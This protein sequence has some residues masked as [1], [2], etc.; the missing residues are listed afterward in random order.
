MN[1]KRIL[2][3]AVAAVM[4][5]AML[6]AAALAGGIVDAYAENAKLALL[7]TVWAELEA[8]ENEL[9]PVASQ[10]T[11][12]VI[13]VYNAAL[14]NSRID[15]GSLS[16]LSSNGFFF[17]VDGM[18][19]A[20]DYRARNSE[21]LSAVDERLLSSVKAAAE[22]VVGVKEGVGSSNVLL[23]GPN[24][25]E[26]LSEAG[27]YDSS[28]TDQYMNEINSIGAVTG[29]SVTIL[30]GHNATGPAIAAAY[31]S[32]GVV[33]YDSHGGALNGTSY[34]CLTTN[35]GITTTDYN[36]GWAYNAGSA[37]YIDGRYIQ[38]HITG[39]L[40]NTIVWMAICQGMKASGNGTTGTAL[41][42]A[43]AGC[44][45]GYSQ[46]VT[47]AGDYVYE[48]TFWNEMKAG[49]T[50]K[51]ALTVMKYVHGIPDPYGTAYPIVMS[52]VDP[53]P[54]NPDAA[55]NVNCELRIVPDVEL[56]SWNMQE[57]VIAY[58]G[59]STTVEFER[60]PE[61]ANNYSLVWSTA[62]GS[63]AQVFGT[64]NKV[65]ISGVS[66]GSTT[67]SAA[68]IKNGQQV[69]TVSCEVSVIEPPALNE[70]VN[71][72]GGTLNFTSTTSNYPWA[73]GV[74]DGVPVAASGNAGVDN[75]TSTMQLVL[76]MEAGEQLTFRWKASSEDD[77]DFLK[78]Y[79]NNTQFGDSLSGETEWA[80]VTYTAAASGTYT[81]QWRFIKDQYVGSYDDCGY[82]DDVRYI[83]NITPG[84]GDVNLD[85]FVTSED[86]LLALRYAMGMQDL[87]A[88]Q[89]AQ[90]D[91]NGDGQVT[92][93]DAL[94]ILRRGM[95]IS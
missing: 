85:G 5:F 29:G 27:Y 47:F 49:A 65:I 32:C 86:A 24:Y 13:A 34:L 2:C 75:S 78:F 19:C 72:E 60:I 36:N 39:T 17:T 94:I 88:E 21:H 12:V 10:K 40:P 7:D 68:V 82:V 46:N 91:V 69:G 23:V 80:T 81:F 95:G 73:T 55:Q 28:F 37:A 14:N 44:V 33:I 22:K 11:E 42:A 93:E 30:G 70:A 45:Y 3:I 41:L 26:D 51:D 43:G 20:Y 62:N 77:Y 1:I 64:F 57:S 92:A 76:Q 71:V 63:V 8:V 38:H 84:S 31:P 83:R 74:V 48:E 18:C 87:S 79:V 59:F 56:E 15:A 16:E 67:V 50:V 89:I 52:P 66:L 54:S 90:G 58:R 61:D 6:P 4:V 9:L 35:T 53:F 25:K